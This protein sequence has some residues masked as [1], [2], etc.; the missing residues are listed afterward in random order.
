MNPINPAP[1]PSIPKLLLVEDDP[2]TRAFL[3]AAAEALPA[4]VDAVA[5]V[6]DALARA[7][8]N[9]Y[10]LWLIDANLPDGD[11]AGLLATLRSRGLR[12]PALAHTAARERAAAEALVAAGFLAVLIKPMPAATLQAAIRDAL[13]AHAPAPLHLVESPPPGDAPIWNDEA[14]L[15]ALHGQ[16]AHVDALRGL[17]LDELPAARSTVATAARDGDGTALRSALHRLQASCGFV[18][19]ARLSAAVAAMQ[20][21]PEV[22]EALDGFLAA[23]DETLHSV[24]R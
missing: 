17:F 1:P 2:T 3:I 6:A 18:G 24:G 12:T 11:G 23:V 8:A 10:A 15:T 14:A 19:A 21:Q 7:G 5:T 4:D 22:A 13:D 20:E 16:Q 9:D